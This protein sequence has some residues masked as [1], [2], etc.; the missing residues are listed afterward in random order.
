L[1]ED[2]FVDAEGLGE[3]AFGP[4]RARDAG[5]LI[6][7]VTLEILRERSLKSIFPRGT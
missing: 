6:H 7:F 3:R 5:E 4:A 2:C 1:D